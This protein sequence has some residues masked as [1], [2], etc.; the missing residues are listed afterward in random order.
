MAKLISITATDQNKVWLISPHPFCCFL[1]AL[2]AAKA[3]EIQF[4]VKMAML[5]VWNAIARVEHKS[6]EIK[7]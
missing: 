1:R 2:R 3:M 5:I 6:V 4:A 7:L